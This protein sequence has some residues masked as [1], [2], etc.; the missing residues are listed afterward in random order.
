MTFRKTSFPP[1]LPPFPPFLFIPSNFIVRLSDAFHSGYSRPG[2]GASTW[3][4]HEGLHLQ[5]SLKPAPGGAAVKGSADTLSFFAPA[6]HQV[7]GGDVGNF[8]RAEIHCRQVIGALAGQETHGSREYS[9]DHRFGQCPADG[10]VV[11][12]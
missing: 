3:A 1:R 10:K 9:Q 5:Y 8:T 6:R 11:V 4:S 2:A 7:P 12:S